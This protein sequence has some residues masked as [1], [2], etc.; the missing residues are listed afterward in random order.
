VNKWAARARRRFAK[1][2]L[3]Q[4]VEALEAEIQECRQTNLRLAELTDVV[5]ELLLP[6][7]QQDTAKIDD[8]LRRYRE[9]VGGPKR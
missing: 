2:P 9:S 7:A 3:Q 8:V 5:V 6:V 4:R 1:S